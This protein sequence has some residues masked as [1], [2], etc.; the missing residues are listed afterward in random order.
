VSRAIGDDL[1][2]QQVRRYLAY[3]TRYELLEESG[4]L[5]KR[6][7][8]PAAI[9][10]N[11]AATSSSVTREIEAQSKAA[12]YDCC[13][14]KFAV[15]RLARTTPPLIKPLAIRERLVFLSHANCALALN[16]LSNPINRK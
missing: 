9:S 7:I 14:I 13:R 10:E 5:A 4:F 16:W 11:P 3:L 1:A 2:D 6:S 8:T 12:A 15:E